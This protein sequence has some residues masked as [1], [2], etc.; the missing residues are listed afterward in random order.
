MRYPHHMFR[1]FQSTLPR[2]ERHTFSGNTICANYISIHAPTRGATANGCNVDCNIRYFNPRS[3]EGSDCIHDKSRKDHDISIHAPTRGATR[4]QLFWLVHTLIS[5]HA[6]TRG[7]TDY[8][9]LVIAE[10]KISIHAP[11]RGATTWPPL[12][13]PHL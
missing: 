3:H 7:A 5:I 2:G 13:L 9:R 4:L 10:I 11:T 1:L 6:P 12:P 8:M